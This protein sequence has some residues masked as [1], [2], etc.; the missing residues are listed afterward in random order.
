MSANFR[1]HVPDGF[2]ADAAAKLGRAMLTRSVTADL[3]APARDVLCYGIDRVLADGPP[4]PVFGSGLATE[5]AVGR[6]LVDAAEGVEDG[7]GPTYAAAPASG[8]GPALEAVPWGLIL[9]VLF[10]LVK[11][12]VERRREPK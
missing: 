6:L 4:K 12:I 11:R 3:L 9:P 5:D 7:S 1:P 2:P 10:D 8:D